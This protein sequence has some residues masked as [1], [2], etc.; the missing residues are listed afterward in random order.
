VNDVFVQDVSGFEDAAFFG[1]EL[2]GEFEGKPGFAEA[3]ADFA[4]VVTPDGFRPALA[5]EVLVEERVE[6]EQLVAR[7]FSS[8]VRTRGG[9][10]IFLGFL[11]FGVH[12]VV[13][14][15]GAAFNFC[16]S[17]LPVKSGGARKKRK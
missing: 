13:Y 16:R 9:V 6:V 15:V 10:V 2:D 3:R 1:V 8:H 5:V 11:V 17:A 4:W 14:C 12:C 7:R